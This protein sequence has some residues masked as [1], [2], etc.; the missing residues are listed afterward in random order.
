MTDSNDHDER[1]KVHTLARA[2]QEASV[3]LGI[4]VTPDFVAEFAGQ[5]AQFP[6]L[7]EQFGGTK[8]TLLVVVGCE[9]EGQLARIA[10]QAGYFC[11]RVNVGFDLAYDRSTFIAVLNDWEWFGPVGGAPPWYSGESWT[12]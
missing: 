12:N 3:D 5:T 2:W 8:G 4:C 1:S 6:I 11:A 10:T 7:I 9:N